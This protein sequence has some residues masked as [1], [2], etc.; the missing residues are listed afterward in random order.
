MALT[1]LAIG[2]PTA[3]ATTTSADPVVAA[4]TWTAQDHTFEGGRTACRRCHIKQYRSWEA[5]PHANALETLPEES[6]SDPACLK[7][8]TTGYG[9]ASGFTSVADTPNLAGVTCEAC[10]GAGSDY[11]DRDTMQDLDAA[12]AAGLVIPTE[13]TCTGCHNSESPTFPGSFNYE[14]MKAAGV[15][16]IGG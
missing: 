2:W 3:E 4:H 15:H 6:R 14:E 7:C 8:H 5:T 1:A 13:A 12:V 16:E 11:K 10:H 9:A